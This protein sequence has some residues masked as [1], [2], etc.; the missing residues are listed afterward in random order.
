MSIR[1]A[2]KTLGKDHPP[3]IIAEMSG[4]H[5]QSLERALENGQE[6]NFQSLISTSK[7]KFA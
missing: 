7:I 6:K 4:N 5:N 1:I 3:L 2:T